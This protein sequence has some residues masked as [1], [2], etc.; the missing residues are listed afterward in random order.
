MGSIRTISKATLRFL[1]YVGLLPSGL[2]KLEV[3]KNPEL[4]TV[5]ITWETPNSSGHAIFRGVDLYRVEES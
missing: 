4:Q 3:K 1:D 5:E 2:L